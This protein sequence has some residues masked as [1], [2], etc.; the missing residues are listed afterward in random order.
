[1]VSGWPFWL[2]SCHWVILMSR[3][4][5]NSTSIKGWNTKCP[6][7]LSE[8]CS[9]WFWCCLFFTTKHSSFIFIPLY[10][11]VASCHLATYQFKWYQRMKYQMCL[12]DEYELSSAWSSLSMRTTW[13]SPSSSPSSSSPSTATRLQ[14]SRRHMFRPKGTICLHFHFGEPDLRLDLRLHG[15]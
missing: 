5:I 12:P 14:V 6:S 1:M 11:G 13:T 8:F 9:S 3:H 4:C 15:K 10:F 7:W 2:M